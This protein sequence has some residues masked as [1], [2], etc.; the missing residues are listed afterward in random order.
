KKLIV[1][2]E[3]DQV[4]QRAGSVGLNASTGNDY[5][6]YY[7]QMPAKRLELWF[8]MESDRLLNPVFREFWSERDVVFEERRLRTENTPLGKFDEAFNATFW[9]A[10]PYGWPVVGWA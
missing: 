5:T 7:L 3:F 10:H 2:N 1:K 4:V 8:K 6:N 9:E